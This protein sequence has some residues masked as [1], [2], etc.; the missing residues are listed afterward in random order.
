[1]IKQIGLPLRGRPILFITRMITDRIGLHSVLLLSHIV[2]AGVLISFCYS[3]FLIFFFFFFFKIFFDF[4]A[5]AGMWLAK[6]SSCPAISCSW[7]ATRLASIV[8]LLISIAFCFHLSSFSCNSF[9][10][11]SISFFLSSISM[12]ARQLRTSIS[13][14]GGSCKND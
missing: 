4:L 10:F 13:S 9:S 8:V 3:P 11:F 5:S 12:A 7:A 6:R 1:M 2:H 14:S